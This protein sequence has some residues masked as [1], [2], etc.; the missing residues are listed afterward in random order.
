MPGIS[1][2]QATELIRQFEKENGLKP[3]I[4][5]G[6]TGNV[7]SFSLESYEKYGLNGCIAKGTLLPDALSEALKKIWQSGI[8][9]FVNLS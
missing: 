4:I 5:L 7:D 9:H 8:N 2:T 6:L 3:K 1:G